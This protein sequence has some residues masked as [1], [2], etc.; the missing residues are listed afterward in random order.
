MNCFE[1]NQTFD[2]YESI[3]IAKKQYEVASNTILSVTGS[4]K[5]KGDGEFVK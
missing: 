1:S 3:L 4:H 5:L 2:S